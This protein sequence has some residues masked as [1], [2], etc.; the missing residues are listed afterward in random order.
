[1]P[2]IDCSRYVR[3]GEPAKLQRKWYDDLPKKKTSSN[4]TKTGTHLIFPVLRIGDFFCM[5]YAL[6][7][8]GIEYRRFLLRFLTLPDRYELRISLI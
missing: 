8:S 4:L 1:M 3:R 2:E 6:D 7:F 5:Q